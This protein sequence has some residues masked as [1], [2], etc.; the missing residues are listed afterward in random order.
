ML[1]IGL[2]E[3]GMGIFSSGSCIVDGVSGQADKRMSV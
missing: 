2:G 1:L 3:K